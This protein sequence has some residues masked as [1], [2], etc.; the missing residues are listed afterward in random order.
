MNKLKKSPEELEAESLRFH[1]LRQER[2]KVAMQ[3]VKEMSK[4]PLSSEQFREQIRQ[5]Q[6]EANKYGKTSLYVDVIETDENGERKNYK[7]GTHK[8]ILVFAYN[9][10]KDKRVVAKSEIFKDTGSVSY[11]NNKWVFDGHKLSRVN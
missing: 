4:H 9:R 3:A 2:S 6:A 10:W 5:H 7:E 11:R 8:Q 1:V